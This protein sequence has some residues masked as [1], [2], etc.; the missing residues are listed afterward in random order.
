MDKHY[1]YADPRESSL[2]SMLIDKK[3]VCSD[4]AKVTIYYCTL[5]RIPCVS[6][7]SVE[8]EWNA[9][10]IQGKWYH[11]DILWRLLFLGDEEIRTYNYHKSPN[12]Y[13]II[14]DTIEK[15]N[16]PES[17]DLS[18][19]LND[20]LSPNHKNVDGY[21]IYIIEYTA[22]FYNKVFG[23]NGVEKIDLDTLEREY[24][25]KDSSA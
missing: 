20:L 19:T 4:Y 1:T 21:Y 24:H 6:E 18:C 7:H 2:H 11:L 5:L 12:S 22:D 10:N 8:H 15:N 9:V 13:K 3:G 14:D 17:T 25:Y 16:F 23:W